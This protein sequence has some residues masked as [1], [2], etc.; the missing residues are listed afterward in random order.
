MQIDLWKSTTNETST[1]IYIITLTIA[2]ND[3]MAGTVKINVTT[4]G[5]KSWK[6][7]S[8]VFSGDIYAITSYGFANYYAVGQN[9]L[10]FIKN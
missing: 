1:N 8:P 6:D 7:E 5:G 9:G 10:I 3:I 2:I 4:D